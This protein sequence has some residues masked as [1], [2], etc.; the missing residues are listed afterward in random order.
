MEIPNFTENTGHLSTCITELSHHENLGP[1]GYVDR[2][3][4]NH[5]SKIPSNGPNQ[6]AKTSRPSYPIQLRQRSLDKDGSRIQ[7]IEIK[8]RTGSTKCQP[9][10]KA[11]AA[12]AENRTYRPA[13]GLMRTNSSSI[14]KTPE[15]V[16]QI[17]SRGPLRIRSASMNAAATRNIAAKAGNVVRTNQI[18]TAQPQNQSNSIT[19]TIVIAERVVSK[20]GVTRK[21]PYVGPE[22]R[23]RAKMKQ[24]YIF[25]NNL[26]HCH[27]IVD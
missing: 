26:K 25:I 9:T 1:N 10:I 3:T 24:K 18:T 7:S 4:T 20:P 15:T 22:T 14:R 19:K 12:S 6:P 2:G 23:A 11:R 27:F 17:Q 8:Q 5:A 16:T 13:I 21:S